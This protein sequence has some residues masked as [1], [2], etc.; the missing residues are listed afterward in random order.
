VVNGI[1][2]FN[3]QQNI[4]HKADVYVGSYCDWDWFGASTRWSSTTPSSAATRSKASSAAFGIEV[5]HIVD[6]PVSVAAGICLM[7]AFLDALCAVVT[8]VTLESTLKEE[9]ERDVL[10]QGS[11]N[12]APSKLLLSNAYSMWTTLFLIMIVPVLIS[13]KPPFVTMVSSCQTQVGKDLEEI[14]SSA[15]SIVATTVCLLLIL[16]GLSRFV[17]RL[18]KH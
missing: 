6:I 5:N 4:H 10:L 13:N 17:E 2:L 9:E 8:E 7:G 1:E 14:T 15:T 16:V 11:K 18:F 3:A 12:G